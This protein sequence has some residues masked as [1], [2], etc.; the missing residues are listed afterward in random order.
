MEEKN[1][2]N[3]IILN[4]SAQNGNNKKLLLAVATLTII[5]I[6]VVVIMNSLKSENTNNLPQAALLP[7]PITQNNSLRDDPLF[8]PVEV[9]EEE[10]AEENRLNKIAQKL[11]AQSMQ[12]EQDNFVIEEE[13]VVV[14]EKPAV[15]VKKAKPARVKP[16]VVVKAEPTPVVHAKKAPTV[17]EY[18]VQVGSFS[19]L[20]PSDAL[21]K[22]IRTQGYK[23]TYHKVTIKG[24]AIKK[25]L[26]GPFAT[27]K[28]SQ[29][30]RTQIKR[31]I[32]PTAF[33]FKMK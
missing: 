11:K 21:L 5:L 32:E 19:K 23:Y 33:I 12:K 30:A 14:V 24:R 17:G 25:V 2:L 1:E 26:I 4:K 15:V 3:D 27:K 13:E 18:Y 16:A 28:E 31:T 20:K 10:S 29:K 7:E 9:I 8:E 6:I 22:K